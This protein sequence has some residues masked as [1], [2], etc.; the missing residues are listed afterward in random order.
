MTNTVNEMLDALS[1][2]MAGVEKQLGNNGEIDNRIS[3]LSNRISDLK[4]MPSVSV[5]GPMFNTADILPCGH[6]RLCLRP[7]DEPEEC[8]ECGYCKVIAACKYHLNEVE[9]LKACLDKQLDVIEEY[10]K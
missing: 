5:A 10:T 6:S 2:R 1:V 3:L 9:K 8:Q 7:I 4:G